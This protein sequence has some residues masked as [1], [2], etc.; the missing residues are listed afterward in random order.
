[1]LAIGIFIKFEEVSVLGIKILLSKTFKLSNFSKNNVEWD[2]FT[3]VDKSLVDHAGSRDKYV[4]LLRKLF[5]SSMSI[6]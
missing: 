5:F 2:K 6:T 3:L 1:M 4:E